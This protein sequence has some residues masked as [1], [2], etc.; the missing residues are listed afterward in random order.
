LV[1]IN[2]KTKLCIV[3]DIYVFTKQCQ[4]VYYTY[5]S[6]FKNDRSWVDWLSIVKT[7]LKGHVQVVQEDNDELN[8]IDDVFQIDKLVDAYQVAMSTDLE[9][10][11]NFYG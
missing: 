11:S 4:Q 5:T 3:D 8:A 2:T 1:K 6:S 7:K 10:N 9:E